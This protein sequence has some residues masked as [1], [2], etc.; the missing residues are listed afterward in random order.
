[1]TETLRAL[2]KASGLSPE[3]EPIKLL[4]VPKGALAHSL[5]QRLKLQDNSNGRKDKLAQSIG[6]MQHM[7]KNS[8]GSPPRSPPFLNQ[9]NPER[10]RLRRGE[11]VEINSYLASLGLRSRQ[12]EQPLV[13]GHTLD[14]GVHSPEQ[15][16]PPPHS[17]TD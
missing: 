5:V 14:C 6:R 16:E 12:K 1:N 7:R 4:S 9:V 11:T 8:F 3:A 2:Q 10:R 13:R 17:E 15:A